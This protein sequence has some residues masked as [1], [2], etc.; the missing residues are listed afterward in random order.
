MNNSNFGYDCR[1]NLDNCKFVPI[2]DEYKEITYINRYH[3]IFDSRVSEFV[4]ADLLKA[5]L[6]EKYND[7]LLKLGKEDRFYE[8]KLQTLK[9]ERL[10]Q[11]EAA[12][13]FDQKTK[14]SKKRTKLVYIVDRKSEALANQKV[15]SLIDLKSIPALLS[16]SLLKKVQKLI[17]PLV[18]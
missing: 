3:N 7:K 15:K 4:T 9:S 17:Y 5:N 10:E 13:K 18:F 1:N 12:E 8:I 11:L 6:E 2:F 16:R 14:K